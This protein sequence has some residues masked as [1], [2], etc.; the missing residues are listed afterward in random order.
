M[1]ARLLGLAACSALLMAFMTF[2]SNGG[3]AGAQNATPVAGP[4]TPVATTG[5]GIVTLVG[6]YTRDSSGNFLN[7]G[8]IDVNEN[9]VAKAGEPTAGS[10]TGRLDFDDPGN[11]DLPRI[12]IGKSILDA[13]PV[14]PDD[15][16]TTQR[17]T[18]YNDDPSLR[19]STLVMQVKAVGG[20]YVGA[21]GTATLVSRSEDGTGVIVI[22]LNL[23]SS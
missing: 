23:K 11:D 6:W 17:W 5:G 22:V 15:P 3:P 2:A 9:M 14:N 16:S 13:V 8:P 19:P 4:S 21:R 1:W 18:Y 7:I 12:R 10:I 20:P